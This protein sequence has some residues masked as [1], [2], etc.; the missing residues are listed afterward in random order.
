M[1]GRAPFDESLRLSPCLNF[2]VM[3]SDRGETREPEPE[4]PKEVRREHEMRRGDCLTSK[5]VACGE[6][7]HLIRLHER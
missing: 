6:L 3:L 1:L 2:A 4:Y 5:R 7:L